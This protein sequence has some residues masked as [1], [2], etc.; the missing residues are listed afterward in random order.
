VDDLEWDVKVYFALNA[1]VHDAACAAWSLKRYYDGGRPI[2]AVRYMAQMGQ[3]S[4]PNAA[5]Y[6]PNGLPLVTNLI[7]VVTPETT[8]PGGRHAGL[9]VGQMAIFAWPGAPADPITEHSGVR[10]VLGVDWLPYQKRTFVTPAFP[11]YISGH[12]TFSRSAAE[13]LADIT[14]SPYFPGGLAG[15]TT[16]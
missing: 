3:S 10:W 7:E 14:G 4:D 5:S 11:G 8:K 13:V 16:S 9:A 15:Y 1:A 2:E 12:S 6:S